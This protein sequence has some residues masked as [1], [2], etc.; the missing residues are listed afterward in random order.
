[1]PTHRLR[2][3]ET[4]SRNGLTGS[5]RARLRMPLSIERHLRCPTAPSET[6]TSEHNAP[7]GSARRN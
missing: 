7:D 2:I 6:D 5:R 4:V 3:R 1:M